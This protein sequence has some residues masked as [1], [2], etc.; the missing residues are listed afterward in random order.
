LTLAEPRL[1]EVSQSLRLGRFKT[2]WK[3]ALFGVSAAGVQVVV[4]EGQGTTVTSHALATRRLLQPF[5]ERWQ[6]EMDEKRL[7]VV[8]AKDEDEAVDT[9]AEKMG[10]IQTASARVAKE[11][12][13]VSCLRW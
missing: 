7:G 3:I 11:G 9:A 2:L 12:S 6:A 8:D 5:M 4:R 10:P 13:Q 1:V